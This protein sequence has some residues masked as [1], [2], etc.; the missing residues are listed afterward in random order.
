MVSLF[1]FFLIIVG[2]A[3]FT[4]TSYFKG[5]IGEF[6][7]NS[8]LSTRLDKYKYTILKNVLLPS[9]DGTT[10][11][12]HIVL[13]EYG[14]F[15]IET[16]NISNWIFC[17]EKGP[18]WRQQI[19]N[20][21]FNFQNPIRQNYKHRKTIEEITG[22]GIEKTFDIIVFAG[23]C[24]FK[25]EMPPCVVKLYKLIGFINTHTDKILDKIELQ[26]IHNKIL[27][28][29][30]ENTFLNKLMHKEYVESIIEEKYN[31]N[32]RSFSS[33][34]RN[35][36]SI[37]DHFFN[38]TKYRIIF[39]LCAFFISLIFL[40]SLPKIMENVTHSLFSNLANSQKNIIKPITR[41]SIQNNNA[42]NKQIPTPTYSTQNIQT[43]FQQ[44][45]PQ[46]PDRQSGKQI[47][48]SWTN[49][50]GH[51]TFSNKGF[52]EDGNFTNGKMERY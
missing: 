52:P 39:K 16:K 28:A 8:I 49:E 51:K 35:K 44:S 50:D 6:K 13:S 11:I 5:V 42:I 9:S 17:Y 22:V 21:K 30:I 31:K 4:K 48:Y 38:I 14:I 43:N 10:Q 33:R 2:A 3:V 36:K 40:L 37:I 24:E 46:Q 27:D 15:V 29:K 7:V 1:I 25:T 45:K 34:G 32:D 23:R 47:I 41:D 19:F 12:D 26:K 20:A 18:M